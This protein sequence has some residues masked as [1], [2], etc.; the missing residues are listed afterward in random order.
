MG[1][2]WL[3]CPTRYCSLV[4]ADDDCGGWI[5]AIRGVERPVDCISGMGMRFSLTFLGCTRVE[6]IASDGWYRLSHYAGDI[7]F[8]RLTIG[9]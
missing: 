9:T 5:V 1:R 4:G 7:L 8:E 2:A 6:Y 3:D